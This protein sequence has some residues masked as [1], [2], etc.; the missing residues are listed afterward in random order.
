LTDDLFSAVNRAEN[1]NNLTDLEKKHLPVMDAPDRVSAGETFEVTVEVGRFLTH[2]SEPGHS[3]QWITIMRGDLTL[4]SV[5]LTP[6]ASPKITVPVKLGKTSE[7]RAIE[8]CN[9][10]GEWEY[11]KKVRVK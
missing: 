2:P 9:L 5:Q 10:H 7:L 6:D 11:T 3:I 1:L 4:A 8:R